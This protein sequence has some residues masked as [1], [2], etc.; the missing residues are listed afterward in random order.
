MCESIPPKAVEEA[1]SAG[2]DVEV[3][4]GAPAAYLAPTP[5]HELEAP[6]AP[7][8]DQKS[9]PREINEAP[10]EG[11]TAAEAPGVASPLQH[12]AGQLSKSGVC[13]YTSRMHGN[14][15]APASDSE[16]RLPQVPSEAA[17]T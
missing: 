17:S 5:E 13:R 15:E 7:G 14:V 9:S 2:G 11:G 12:Y 4:T 6:I 16:G 10:A 3:A 8:D 1:L